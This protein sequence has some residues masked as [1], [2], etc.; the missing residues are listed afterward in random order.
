MQIFQNR[1]WGKFTLKSKDPYLQGGRSQEAEIF[2]SL[3]L[4]KD[5][6]I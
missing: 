6:L 2:G 3:I 5:T 1:E 4:C